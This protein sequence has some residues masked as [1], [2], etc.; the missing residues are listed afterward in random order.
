[1]TDIFK[2]AIEI[3][4]IKDE[5]VGKELLFVGHTFYNDYPIVRKIQMIIRAPR[6]RLVLFEPTDDY[7]KSRN[8]IGDLVKAFMK[9]HSND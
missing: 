4:D 8:I 7:I 6:G 2:G 5:N 3:E 1:M 9:A